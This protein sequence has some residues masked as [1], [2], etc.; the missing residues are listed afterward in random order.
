ML[1]LELAALRARC[2]QEMAGRIP[3]FEPRGITS[4]EPCGV[5]TPAPCGV[6]TPP[7]GGCDGFVLRFLARAASDTCIAPGSHQRGVFLWS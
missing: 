5:K 2:A 6:R 1:S 3:A 7:S 4:A